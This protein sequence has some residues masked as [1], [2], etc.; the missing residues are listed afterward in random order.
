VKRF[1]G[2]ALLVA[3]ASDDETRPESENGLQRP[4]GPVVRYRPDLAW[5]GTYW[6]GDYFE[7]NDMMFWA[8]LEAVF[9]VGFEAA[10]AESEERVTFAV[11]GRANDAAHHVSSANY[12]RTRPAI[13]ADLRRGRY[14][15]L[16]ESV[17]SSPRH[18]INLPEPPLD[19]V[20]NARR[21]AWHR[22]YINNTSELQFGRIDVLINE[23]THIVPTW[24][25][26]VETRGSEER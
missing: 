11:N 12:F 17:F 6:T 7:P 16:S 15:Y 21:E 8:D 25:L 2:L 26:R 5:N 18:M 13:H 19:F 20:K 23:E 4:A 9:L 10:R 1:A 3:C 14:C 22:L 24:A